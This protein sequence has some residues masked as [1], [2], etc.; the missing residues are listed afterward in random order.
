MSLFVSGKQKA[1][2]LVD[3]DIGPENS[4]AK[5]PNSSKSHRSCESHLLRIEFRKKLK[6]KTARC[7]CPNLANRQNLSFSDF[8]VNFVYGKSHSGGLRQRNADAKKLMKK[9]VRLLCGGDLLPP[10]SGTP[11]IPAG[12]RRGYIS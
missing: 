7:F 8:R 6:E 2:Y 1:K 4:C 3:V 10:P 11:N 12:R 5:P 9:A